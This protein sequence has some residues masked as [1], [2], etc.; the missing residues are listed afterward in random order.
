MMV[1]Q[2]LLEV[3]ELAVK[4]LLRLAD[5]SDSVENCLDCSCVVF[6]VSIL[7]SLDFFPHVSTADESQDRS[8]VPKNEKLGVPVAVDFRLQN[9]TFVAFLEIDETLSDVR[10]N[11]SSLWLIYFDHVIIILSLEFAAGALD[12]LELERAA[13]IP[14]LRAARLVRRERALLR[15]LVR[16]ARIDLALAV[17]AGDCCAVFH[18]DIILSLV[19]LREDRVRD[20]V[21]QLLCVL[22]RCAPLGGLAIC[23]LPRRV[24]RV[25]DVRGLPEQRLGVNRVCVR[26]HA[27]I[28]LSLVLLLFCCG[29][30]GSATGWR[31]PQSRA[32]RAQT[33]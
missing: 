3:D 1:R 25:A 5:D 12:V 9:R 32:T 13:E 2:M 28:I 8:A 10:E 22:V 31:R 20:A 4:Q 29:F 15:E 30:S 6:H 11:D 23:R 7:L 18:D 16:R 24:Q 21:V 26:V 14:L 27:V 19:L 17:G 33:A